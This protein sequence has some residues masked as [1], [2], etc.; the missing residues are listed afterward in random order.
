M[1]LYSTLT[2]CVDCSYASKVCVQGC[3]DGV[4][5][6]IYSRGVEEDVLINQHSPVDTCSK[7][8]FD[9]V[10]SCDR[11]EHLVVGEKTF[12][13]HVHLFMRRGVVRGR[14]CWNRAWY[15]RLY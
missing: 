7:L 10:G 6:R 9:S 15:E 1:Y 3:V 12:V 8:G 13:Y 2:G 5:T 14:G 4:Y 11:C